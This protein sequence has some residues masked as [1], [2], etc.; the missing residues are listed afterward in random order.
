MSNVRNMRLTEGERTEETSE[1]NTNEKV[2]R[3]GE[4]YEQVNEYENR[5]KERIVGK[6]GMK[7]DMEG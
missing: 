6:K 3:I 7:I 1:K 2:D 4:G 5:K